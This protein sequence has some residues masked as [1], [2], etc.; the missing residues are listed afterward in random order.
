[1][2]TRSPTILLKIVDLPTF[3]R[4]T[5]ATTGFAII[6]PSFFSNPIYQTFFSLS[7][8]QLTGN[9]KF[10]VKNKKSLWEQSP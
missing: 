8:K 7:V 5:I 1:M 6:S 3:G 9:E 4:P 2:E 10:D